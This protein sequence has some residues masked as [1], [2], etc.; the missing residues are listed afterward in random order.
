MVIISKSRVF[1]TFNRVME[2]NCNAGLECLKLI[3]YKV[4]RSMILTYTCHRVHRYV[5]NIRKIQKLVVG[6]GR[7]GEHTH[8]ADGWG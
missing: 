1:F 3:V 7:L 2:I 4:M 6:R 5:R 8:K